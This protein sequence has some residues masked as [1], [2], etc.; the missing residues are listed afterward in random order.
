M[1]VL[2]TAAVLSLLCLLLSL[3]AL[4]KAGRRPYAILS[5]LFVLFLTTSTD[6]RRILPAI[7][8][9]PGKYNW[10]GKVL[11]LLVS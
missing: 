7:P 6:L 9:I 1:G 10:T 4:S 2:L 3:P 8:N 11:E 5:A